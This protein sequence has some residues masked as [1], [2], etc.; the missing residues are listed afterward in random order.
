MEQL[1]FADIQYEDIIHIWGLIMEQ[2]LFEDIQYDD[3]IFEGLLWSNFCLKTYSK[4]S[5][6]NIMHAYWLPVP[7]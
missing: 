4:K 3:I 2:L 1:L 6:I 7:K 5:I